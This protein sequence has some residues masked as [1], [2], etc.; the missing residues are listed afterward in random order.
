[1]LL[2]ALGRTPVPRR[3]KLG[4]ALAV[5]V[6]GLLG[7]GL[8]F[9]GYFAKG[10]TSVG[11]RFDYW[12]AAGKTFVAN[13]VLGSGPGTFLAAYQK[14]KPPE[15]EMARLAHNDF[16]QQA[17]DSGTVGALA[18]AAFFFGSVFLLYR[19]S[20]VR[21]SSFAFLVWLGLAGW[22]LQSFIEFGLYVPAIAWPGFAL[23][24]WLWG[25]SARGNQIDTPA[26]AR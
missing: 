21:N 19:N 20:H 1:M 22:G 4:V 7:F 2:V 14:I 3:M 13:P 23:L 25:N 26:A 8:R 17:S 6:L 16:L 11:A 24:G 12:R 15:A 9:Q 10:A 18:F 5:A